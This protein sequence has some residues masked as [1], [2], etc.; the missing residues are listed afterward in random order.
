MYNNVGEHRF[1]HL[2]KYAALFGSLLFLIY[3]V[4]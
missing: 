2:G 1:S 3:I 4:K